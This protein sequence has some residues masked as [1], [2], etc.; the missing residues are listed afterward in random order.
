MQAAPRNSTS[1]PDAAFADVRRALGEM[2]T[3]PCPAQI[4]AIEI[5]WAEQNALEIDADGVGD[6]D[7]RAERDRLARYY[8]ARSDALQS[9]LE[10]VT[11]KSWEGIYGQVLQLRRC[12][13]DL[14]GGTEP[15]LAVMD[16][17]DRLQGRILDALEVLAG[18]NGEVLGRGIFGVPAEE[19][20]VNF[21]A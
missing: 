5:A 2:V 8:F 20:G 14:T 4:L 15:A 17:I 9:Q 21:S 6:Q 12:A 16:R 19:F 3:R 1:S 10:W 7:D 11:S 18:V 13:S